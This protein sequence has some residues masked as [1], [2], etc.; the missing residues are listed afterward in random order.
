MLVIDPELAFDHIAGQFCIVAQL[1]ENPMPAV[2][3]RVF[4]LQIGQR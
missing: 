3:E 2:R 4:A 1:V